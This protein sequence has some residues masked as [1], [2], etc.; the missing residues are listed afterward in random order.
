MKIKNIKM[1]L[2]IKQVL[3]YTENI[4]YKIENKKYKNK[5]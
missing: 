5:K 1:K 3:K 2:K 4:K